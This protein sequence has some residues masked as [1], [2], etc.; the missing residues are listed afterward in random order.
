[1]KSRLSRLQGSFNVVDLAVGLDALAILFSLLSP[2]LS[3][4]LSYNVHRSKTEQ[5]VNSR[6]T[7]AAVSLA[8]LTLASSSSSFFWKW[9]IALC[10]F[11]RS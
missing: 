2:F 9:S 11:A 1:L 8:A 4:Q 6:W 3:Q 7:N 5:T 10:A